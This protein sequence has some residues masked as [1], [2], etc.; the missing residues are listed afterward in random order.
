MKTG[1]CIRATAF[2]SFALLAGCASSHIMTSD[3]AHRGDSAVSIPYSLP[4]GLIKIH[5]ARDEHDVLEVD[6]LDVVYEPDPA[7]QYYLT[8]DHSAFSTDTVSIQTTDTG[9]LKKISAQSKDERGEVLKKLVELATE[10][11][12]AFIGARGKAIDPYPTFSYETLFD[13]TLKED[14]DRLIADLGEYGVEILEL[15]AAPLG[16]ALSRGAAQDCNRG[17]CFRLAVPHKFVIA[18]RNQPTI[19]FPDP[20]PARGTADILIPNGSPILAV[21]I[22][23]YAFVEAKTEVEFEN[24]MLTKV[25]LDKPSEAV[26]FM[27]IPIDIAKSIV[28]IPSALFD[29]KIKSMNDDQR[30]NAA[31]MNLIDSQMRLLEKQ[32]ELLDSQDDA[33]GGAK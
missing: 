2:A 11:G 31:Q 15:D 19:A 8:Y 28:S 18:Y 23:R 30:L 1:F 32:Q 29:F 14:R 24:G 26:G 33:K 16:G 21:E 6:V 5:V 10:T 20:T 17:A 9:L 25:S 4:R 3:A 22:N 7:H 27:E 13:P 12:K